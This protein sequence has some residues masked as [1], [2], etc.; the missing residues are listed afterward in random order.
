[1]LTA[2]AKLIRAFILIDKS[3]KSFIF[4]KQPQGFAKLTIRIFAER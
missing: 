1:M 2:F 4:L 3:P